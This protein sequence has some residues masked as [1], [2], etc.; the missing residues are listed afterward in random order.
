MA[1]PLQRPAAAILLLLLLAAPA[2]AQTPADPARAFVPDPGVLA[3]GGATVALPN[4]ATAFFYNPAHLSAVPELYTPVT[5]FGLRGGFS[6]NVFDQYRFWRDDVDPAVAQGFD[7]LGTAEQNRLFDEALALGR[8]R[9]AVSGSMLLPAFALNRGGYSL[10]AGLYTQSDVR[11]RAEN[12]GGGVP[13]ID[14]AG[15]VDLLGVAGVA[16]P[17]TPALAVG[18]VGKVTDR[19]LTLKQKPLDALEPDETVNLL[20][21]TAVSLDAGAQL[22]VPLGGAR[23]H[24]GGAV[25]DA[26]STEFDYRLARHY[27]SGNATPDPASVRAEVEA[28]QGRYQFSP[29]F[30]VGAGLSWPRLGPLGSTAL[31]LDYVD[32]EAPAVQSVALTRV[33]AGLETQATPWLALRAGLH[34]GYPT[35]GAGLRLGFVRFDYA[36]YGVEEGRLPGQLPSWHHLFQLSFGSLNP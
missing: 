30:R 2:L 18:F 34:Q 29:S 15:R 28:A 20:H 31:A 7:Q 27:G 4:A 16:L 25:Y 8:K 12:L 6:S 21:G 23:L 9:T 10:G 11:Y 3:R 5:F 13:G 32:Y 24:V 17:I 1:H 19:Y 22:T 36:Y 26:V 33:Y 14:A 35:A